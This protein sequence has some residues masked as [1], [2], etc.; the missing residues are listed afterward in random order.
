MLFEVSV[1]L[2][3]MHQ[4]FGVQLKELLKQYRQHPKT[5]IYR[6]SL[7]P[8]GEL[9][10]DKRKFRKGCP[11]KLTEGDVSYSKFGKLEGKCW[12]FFLS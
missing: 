6:Y 4:K 2:R 8:F 5:S 1:E 11:R 7:K 9:K 12:Y 3:I 10:Q